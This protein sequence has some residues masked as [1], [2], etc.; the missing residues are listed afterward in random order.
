MTWN[1]ANLKADKSLRK[2][3]SNFPQEHVVSPTTREP[4]IPA[5]EHAGI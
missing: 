2:M 5:H 4:A 1:F 3:W